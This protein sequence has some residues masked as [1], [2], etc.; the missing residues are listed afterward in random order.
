[1]LDTLFQMAHEKGDARMQAVAVSSKVDHFYFYKQKPPVNTEDS[2]K[3]Y[4]NDAQT[5]AR[6]TNQPLYYY[7]TWSRLI[8][9]YDNQRKYNLALYEANKMQK[10]AEASGDTYGMQ[11]CYQALY[12]IY[13]SRKLYRQAITYREKEI[14]IIKKYHLNDYNLPNHYLTLAVCHMELNDTGKA[15]E[16]LEACKKL[17]L[18]T[19]QRA[20]YLCVMLRCYVEANKLADAKRTLSEA[21]RAIEGN[22]EAKSRYSGDLLSYASYYYLKTGEPEKALEYYQRSLGMA[23]K[24]NNVD[25]IL[26]DRRL[27]AIYSALHDYARAAQ[28]YQRAIAQEDSLQ[29][30]NADLAV[31]E[32]ATILNL[33]NLERQNEDLVRQNEDITSRNRLYIIVLLVV[34]LIL[35]CMELIRERR[36]NVSLKRAK[37]SEERANLMKTEFIQNMSHEIR[38]PLNSIVGFSQILCSEFTDNQE[39]QEYSNIIEQSSN[40]L[41]QLI[42]DVLD[43]SNLDS[44]AAISTH[45]GADVTTICE[46]AI[47][48]VRSKLKPDVVFTFTPEMKALRIQTSP[49]RVLQVLMH[50]LQNA[51]KFTEKGTINLSWS[52]KRIHDKEVIVFRVTDTGIGIP[53]DKCEYVFERFTKLNTFMPGT[54]L[55][56]PICRLIAEKMGGSL[57]IDNSYTDGTCMVMTLPLKRSS[58]VTPDGVKHFSSVVWLTPILGLLLPAA[59][60]QAQESN[61]MSLTSNPD[62]VLKAYHV[63]CENNRRNPAVM[64]MTDTLLRM[65]IDRDNLDA[66]SAAYSIKL[67]HFYF[68]RPTEEDSIM[69]YAKAAMTF[70]KEHRNSKLYYAS[71]NRI[72]NQYIRT[73]RYNLALYEI[74]KMRKEAEA[75]NT[76]RGLQY[77]YSSLY[78]IYVERELYRQA[79]EYRELEIQVIL[80]NFPDFNNIAGS[81]CM[82][83]LCYVELGEMKKAKETLDKA[84]KYIDNDNLQFEYNV[85]MIQYYVEDNQLEEARKYIHKSEELLKTGKGIIGGAPALAYYKF[86]YYSK[87]GDYRKALEEHHIYFGTDENNYDT[88]AYQLLAETYEGLRNTTLALRYY[89]QYVHMKDSIFKHTENNA[90]N[91]FGTILGKD[92]LEHEN[93]Q[94]LLEKQ[95]VE[96]RMIYLLIIIMG[97]FMI[98]TVLIILYQR[99]IN[100]LLRQAKKTEEDSNRMK[101]EFIRNMSHEIRT[102]LNS[103]VGFS[104]ILSAQYADSEETREMS[105]IIEQSTNN[106]LLL[107]DD[108]LEMS[109]LDNLTTI[110]PDTTVD[111]AELCRLCIDRA[112]I[113]VHSGVK[114]VFVNEGAC[115]I[116]T[117]SQRLTQLLNHL[118]HN[119][120]KF[121][122]TGSITLDYHAM[123]EQHKKILEISITDTGIGIPVDKQEFVFERFAKIDTFVPGAGLGLSVCRAIAEKMEGSLIIDA[124]YTNG[125]RFVLTLPWIEAPEAN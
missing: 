44:E 62:S 118:L 46:A 51:A 45:T 106:L 58:D 15:E 111:L 98:T 55:G 88:D 89:K 29:S 42:N 59:T 85:S 48:Q 117:N 77:C 100:R 25:P 31:G 24:D 82:L 95:T 57:K 61:W 69:H 114:M 37:E 9:Y 33:E 1:M 104:Q 107:V 12:H 13:F 2:I 47:N 116:M 64:Q 74:G 50:L 3:K 20:A 67:E 75:T 40:S 6:Q 32:F 21:T 22:S 91:E 121:T 7:F 52:V 27:G 23:L 103:I 108:V 54:G 86:L 30:V 84:V 97:L 76:P 113:H 109:T 93:Q 120:T 41:L 83:G 123:K 36:L 66:Q 105:N 99:R 110:P 73:E 115:Y 78:R 81:Y 70:A 80:D 43:L 11:F 87:I 26:S 16:A 35:F 79:A 68:Y 72:V 102:P 112:S 71:W 19:L 18:S 119:A 94:I 122:P 60:L 4:V 28:H 8:N 49:G 53:R 56:L 34:V 92:A 96:L 125:C 101:T 63:R 14:E 10:E 39:T 124:A 5:F 65:A 38:T 90:I 17:S